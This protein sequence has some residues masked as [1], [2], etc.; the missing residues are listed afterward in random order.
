M[1]EAED[2]AES[3][4]VTKI[5]VVFNW[6]TAKTLRTAKKIKISK[7]IAKNAWGLLF[8]ADI[9]FMIQKIH[10]TDMEV[11]PRDVAKTYPHL[12]PSVL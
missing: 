6:S 10:R 4:V 3:E 7:K 11:V 9:L 5:S 12:F 2:K 1:V 8:A